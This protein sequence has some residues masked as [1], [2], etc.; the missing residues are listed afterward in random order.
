MNIK[1][2]KIKNIYTSKK[3]QIL[4]NRLFCFCFI[5]FKNLKFNDIKIIN[6]DKKEQF[7]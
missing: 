3:F 5:Y 2:I 6:K 4:K 7:I 1:F